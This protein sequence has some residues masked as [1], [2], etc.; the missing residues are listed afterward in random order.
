M[1]RGSGRNWKFPAVSIAS[2]IISC[3]NPEPRV[4]GTVRHTISSLDIS[5]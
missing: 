2:S 5:L 1:K 3:T 4:C